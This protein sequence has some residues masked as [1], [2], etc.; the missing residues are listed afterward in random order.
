[1][2]LA[3]IEHDRCGERQASNYVWVAEGMIS[4]EFEGLVDEARK[5]YL[6]V[7]EGFEKVKRIK[8]PGSLNWNAVIN[9]DRDGAYENQTVGEVKKERRRRK[10]EWEEFEKKAKAARGSFLDHLIEVA[11][12]RIVKFYDFP[13]PIFI[14][15]C[16]WDHRHGM[17]L[18]FGGRK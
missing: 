17:P 1:M 13:D 9:D 5:S 12:G 7:M 18:D 8:N 4:T 14:A 10:V 15:E 16:D 3:R 2:K 11:A 6:A